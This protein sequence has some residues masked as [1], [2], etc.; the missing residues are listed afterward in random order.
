MNLH[1]PLDTL[2]PAER[3]RTISLTIIA[4]A[5]VLFFLASAQFVMIALAT[6][7]ILFSITSDVINFIA[8]QKIGVLRIPP[9]AASIAALALIAIALIILSTVLISQVNSVVGITL[10]YTDRAPA[11]IAELFAFMGPDVKSSILATLAGFDISAYLQT[12][13]G[14]ASN[15]VSFSIL[16][17][18]FVGFLFAE[19][20]WFDVKLLNL[21]GQPEQARRVSRIAESIMHRVNYYLLVKTII[22]AVTGTLIYLIAQASGLEL[23]FALAILTFVLN[24][25]PNIGS[26]AASALVALVAYVQ[27]GD[28]TT[29]WIVFTITS[30][31]QFAMGNII[32]PML[33]GRALRLSSFGIIISLAFWGTLWGLAGMFLAVPIMVMMLVICSHV[34]WLR[35]IAVLLSREGLPETETE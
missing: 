15:L 16:V 25:I 14:Q 7:I 34:N 21:L 13:A 23:A 31:I 33:M 2:S 11:A 28:S 12:L 19:R 29:V 17:I 5:V 10:S 1:R 20:I 3:L 4:G 6:S 8:K 24:Y 26:I 35:P 30:I 9:W 22:S 32:E 27:T 18:L